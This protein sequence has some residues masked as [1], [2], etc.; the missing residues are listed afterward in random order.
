MLAVFLGVAD[1]KAKA[2]AF[3]FTFIA[4]LTTGFRVEW[5]LVQNNN[6]FLTGS[7]RVDRFTVNKQR[8][9]FAVQFG[10]RSL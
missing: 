9:D 3:Q 7:D 6:R 4:N 8:S 2:R 5:R 10:G 1:R